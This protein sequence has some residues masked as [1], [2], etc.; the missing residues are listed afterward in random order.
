MNTLQVHNSNTSNTA[1][2][3]IVVI[4][5]GHLGA[6]HTRLLTS[7]AEQLHIVVAGIYD[8]RQERAETVAT[9]YGIEQIFSSLNDALDATDAVIIVTPTST[10]YALAQAA[11]HAGKHCFI[12]KP[13]ASHYHE[14]IELVQA[15][16]RQGLVVH[17]G[18]VERFNPALVAARQRFDPHALS[19]NAEHEALAPLF[20]E[21]HRLA[22]F[23]PRATDVS[24]ILDL[25]IH[26][27]DIVLQL[28]SSPLV[29]IDAN[30]V[31]ILTDT[32]DIA[33][34]RLR[35]ANGCVANL[36]A[37]RITQKPMRK[38]RIFQRDAYC[39]MDFATGDVE[40][41]RLVDEGVLAMPRNDGTH[42]LDSSLQGSQTSSLA[43]MLGNIE[44]GTRKRAIL[45]EKPTAPPMNAIAEEQKLF[46]QAIRSL[47]TANQS[48]HSAHIAHGFYTQ[49]LPLAFT[50]QLSATHSTGVSAAATAAQAAEAL[51]VA[52]EIARQIA[53]QPFSPS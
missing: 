46:V 53:L 30:G 47:Q 8:S 51:R 52:E 19:A 48:A 24:V 3:R 40:V 20:I 28:V 25:M 22:Q 6:I 9:E 10:H 5:V 41:F 49:E 21:A 16:E 15:A 17:V 38:M 45:F 39:S 12:E 23:K 1:P 29:Q 35:F 36:T 43:V 34:A 37:S 14:A 26:D 2:L 13:I 42:S 33:N 50:E 11:L 18:H 31:A 44:A 32:P 7:S 4:G 27:I